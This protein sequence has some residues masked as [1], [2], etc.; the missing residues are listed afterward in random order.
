MSDVRT[1]LVIGGGIAGPVAAMALRK[2]GIEATIHEAYQG[3]ADGVGG[4]LGI[5]PNGMRALGALDAEDVVLRV[6]EPVRSMI[7]ESWTG[8]RLAE[9]GG[10]DGPPVFHSV[11]RADL[12]RE[13]YDMTVARGIRIEHGKRLV[14]AV[15]NGDGVTAYFADGTS[16]TG[17][18]LIGADGIRST[19]R[20]MIDPAAPRPRYTG[21]LGF[22]GRA[23]NPGL[24]STGH[25]MH[26]TFGK[27]AFFA[28]QVTDDGDT[29]WFI[30]L[31]QPKSMSAAQTRS[32][33]AEE[34][35]PVLRRAVADDR[36]PAAAI[37]NGV[38]PSELIMVGGLEDLPTVPTWSKGRIVL[39]GDSAHATSP[40]SGQ[41][42]SIA[43][44]S[45]IQM[46]R[47]LRDLPT[48]PDA[49][50]T[51]ERLRRDRV[52]R[53]IAAG[54]RTNSEKAAG[55]VARVLRDLILP[56]TMK[57]LAKPEKTAWQT[58]YAIDWDAPVEPVRTL[59]R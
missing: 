51:Y 33:G 38:E 53:I 16:A 17:D 13:M 20:P 31:P 46:A 14:R 10:T 43:I 4:M 28:Y 56:T 9:F 21:L 19:V 49:F 1:A 18:V 59:A 12:Y 54:A 5:A 11:W 7:I 35:L 6:G 50:A 48:V 58:D 44:E 34:W 8:K 39:V 22:G 24:A 29:G 25:S 36:T 45:A 41:G 57:L 32:I 42:A 55:P 30:N 47:C 23:D 37:L 3:T 40:S 15:D 2:A 52:E 26:M 27:R